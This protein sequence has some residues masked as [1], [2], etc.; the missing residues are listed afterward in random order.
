MKA[1]VAGT[2][3][4]LFFGGP[5]R[6]LSVLGCRAGKR[7]RTAALQKLAPT[8][9]ALENREASSSAPALWRFGNAACSRKLSELPYNCIW[10]GKL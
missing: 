3:L 8:R 2:W 4:S 9:T 7:Q 6:R 10:F 5:D 1:G